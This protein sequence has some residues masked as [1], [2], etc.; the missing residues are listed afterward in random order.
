MEASYHQVLDL[1][2]GKVSPV[3]GAVARGYLTS[4]RSVYP[5][6]SPVQAICREALLSRVW[7]I[8]AC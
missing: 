4:V 6:E 5:L 3:G 7:F 8:G 2:R 1:R